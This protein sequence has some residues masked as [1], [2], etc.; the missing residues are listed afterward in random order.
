M[1]LRAELGRKSNVAK[2]R[3]KKKKAKLAENE[4]I[5]DLLGDG[6]LSDSELSISALK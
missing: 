1:E 3:G 6:A 2:G 5:I 4:V